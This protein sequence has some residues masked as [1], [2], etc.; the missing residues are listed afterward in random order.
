M[1]GWGVINAP[2]PSEWDVINASSLVVGV[3]ILSCFLALSVRIVFGW[4]VMKAPAPFGW[5]VKA[6][7]PV[8]KNSMTL[9]RASGGDSSA[10]MAA[11]SD[12]MSVVGGGGGG[13]SWFS[14]RVG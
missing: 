8:R 14:S 6:P 10:T 4:G 7:S 12:A 9:R 5:G 2:S 1:V 11:I 3:L 13:I